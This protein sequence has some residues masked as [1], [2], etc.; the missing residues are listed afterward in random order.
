MKKV[1]TKHRII[2][3]VVFVIYIIMLVYVMFFA[4]V[5]GR[6]QG[7][8]DYHYNF[9]PFKEIMRFMK[10]HRVLGVKVVLFNILGNVLAF[11][12]FGVFLSA[13]TNHRYNC[14]EMMFLTLD[15]SLAIEVLQLISKVGSF[16]ID[17]IILNTLGGVLGY[18]IFYLVMKKRKKNEE[19]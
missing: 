1:K 19:E 3:G 16:D 8:L 2:S 5:L 14:R 6:S 18:F 4:D 13:L 17:D 11:V 15:L 7:F 9:I 10:Y 12:P